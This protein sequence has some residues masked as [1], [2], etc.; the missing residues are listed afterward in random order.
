M[1]GGGGGGGG[2]ALP[3]LLSKCIGFATKFRAILNFSGSLSKCF[4][5]SNPFTFSYF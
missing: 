4:I 5:F 3:T 1:S 2:G